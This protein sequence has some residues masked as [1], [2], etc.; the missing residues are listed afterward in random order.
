ME[1]HEFIR[2]I[3]INQ[4]KEQRLQW[5]FRTTAENKV[6]LIFDGMPHRLSLED[7]LQSSESSKVEEFIIFHEIFL[8][9]NSKMK[10][11]FPCNPLTNFSKP[12]E[13]IGFG[14]CN[15]IFRKMEMSSRTLTFECLAENF[16]C[17]I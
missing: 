16:K 11:Y 7:A 1:A 15:V 10:I 8:Q 2:S 4:I 13:A 14:E 9:H 3:V 17:I 12:T 5:D 6:H